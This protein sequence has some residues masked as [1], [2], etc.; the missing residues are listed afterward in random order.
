LNKSETKLA[1]KFWIEDFSEKC[2]S[3]TNR[4]NKKQPKE[5]EREREKVKG[6]RKKEEKGEENLEG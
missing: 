2:E 6:K 3:T 4:E 1:T 5:R